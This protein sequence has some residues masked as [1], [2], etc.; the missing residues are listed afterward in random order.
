MLNIDKYFDNLPW[1]DAE[2][3]RLAALIEA[4]QLPHAILLHGPAGT[5]R[6]QLALWLSETLLSCDL[7][8]AAESGEDE[9][10]L[11]P[12]LVIVEPEP[13]KTAIGIDRIRELIDFMNLTGHQGPARCALIYPAEAMTVNAANSLLKTLEEPPPGVVL[14]LICE[15]IG[16]LPATVVSRCQRFRVAPPALDAGRD[17]LAGQTNER[18]L[19]P[20]LDFAGGAPLA[21]LALCEQAFAGL[22]EGFETDLANLAA[23][24]AD[25]VRVAAGWAKQPELALRWLYGHM[26]AQLRDELGAGAAETGQSERLAAYFRQLDQ[27]RELRRFIAGSVNAELGL[28][29]LLMDWYGDSHAR[30]T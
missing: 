5:G 4:G 27:I 13:D 22:A 15:T 9:V 2:R 30:E 23:R 26:A 28:T 11:H 16:R 1:L 14:V 20:I 7:R 3:A 19:D 25:P 12:D 29:E 21:A 6:R 10:D 18:D 8:H 17:W 24:R